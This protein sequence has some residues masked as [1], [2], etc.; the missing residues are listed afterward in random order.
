MPRPGGDA[1]LWPH[2]RPGSGEFVQR[3]HQP[4]FGEGGTHRSRQHR[5]RCCS[6]RN[7]R[8]AKTKLNQGSATPNCAIMAAKPMR[9]GGM[10]RPRLANRRVSTGRE[11][12]AC[13]WHGDS[14]IVI[15][16]RPNTR[17]ALHCQVQCTI[18]LVTRM[19]CGPWFGDWTCWSTRAR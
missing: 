14:R 4:V 16:Q 19:S 15:S 11:A 12:L 9:N 5:Q 18:R 13:L 7:R 3:A 8:S 10:H 2:R 1:V 6:P 17:V